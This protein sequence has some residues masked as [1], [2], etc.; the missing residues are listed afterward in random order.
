MAMLLLVIGVLQFA[1]FIAHLLWLAELLLWD[2][3]MRV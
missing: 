1:I 2:A 3:A